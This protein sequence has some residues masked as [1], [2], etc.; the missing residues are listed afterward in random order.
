MLS[1]FGITIEPGFR[2]FH[3]QL[4]SLGFNDFYTFFFSFG[5]DKVRSSVS[6]LFLPLA[7]PG[8]GLSNSGSETMISYVVFCHLLC[9]ASYLLLVFCPFWFWFLFVLSPFSLEEQWYSNGFSI[10]SLYIQF[11]LVRL[12]SNS[13]PY[14]PICVVSG[15]LLEEHCCSVLP[16]SQV[17]EHYLKR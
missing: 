8:L 17:K 5:R 1:L 10:R 15:S 11:S 14:T 16:D 4:T 9:P 3:F 13:V 7:G 12:M 2:Q 6:T